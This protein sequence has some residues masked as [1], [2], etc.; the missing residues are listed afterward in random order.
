MRRGGRDR[1]SSRS[2]RSSLQPPVSSA[3]PGRQAG[4]RRG[5]QRRT[6]GALVAA[7]GRERAAVLQHGARHWP[8][9]AGLV[10]L[11]QKQ[12]ARQRLARPPRPVCPP[13]APSGGG[14]HT[15]Q[16]SKGSPG[17]QDTQLALAKRQTL[18]LVPGAR[19]GQVAAGKLGGGERAERRETRP[20]TD[21]LGGGGWDA[22]RELCETHA[23]CAGEKTCQAGR[24]AGRHVQHKV[25]G[26]RLLSHGGAAGRHGQPSVRAPRGSRAARRHPR[27]RTRVTRQRSPPPHERQGCVPGDME[28]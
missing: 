19:T 4:R 21:N 7:G 6:L 23:S 24:Q 20:A 11:A 22:Q 12:V 27:P 18:P 3:P 2:P 8:G 28:N 26:R 9:S 17:R 16:R 14:K 13:S 25:Q 1:S 15:A 5:G 10:K